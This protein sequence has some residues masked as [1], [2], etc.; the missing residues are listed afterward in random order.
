MLVDERQPHFHLVVVSLCCKD[1][2]TTL[3]WKI[4][5]TVIKRDEDQ[6]TGNGPFLTLY[7]H[8]VLKAMKAMHV[9]VYCFFCS[10][11][12]LYTGVDFD[13]DGQS[14]G[15]GVSSTCNSWKA[16][17]AVDPLSLPQTD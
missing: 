13:P 1:S 10:I 7:N 9:T 17:S 2:R 15:P 8:K 5:L 16:D 11:D 3:Q 14:C 6:K 4:Q 12:F